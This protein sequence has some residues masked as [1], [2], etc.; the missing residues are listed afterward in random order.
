VTVVETHSSLVLLGIQSLVSERVIA[1]DQVKLH[2]FQRNDADGATAIS[3][4]G[5]DDC[6]RFGKWPADFDDVML[7]AQM[8]YLN[9][10]EDH[11]GQQ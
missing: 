2:W 9:S 3:T 10:S 1:P 4:A 7:K 11:E 6:G 5:L 8:R